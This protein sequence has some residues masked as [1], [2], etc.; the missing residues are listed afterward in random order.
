MIRQKYS[1]SQF[2]IKNTVPAAFVLRA[3]QPFERSLTDA[4]PIDCLSVTP[5]NLCLARIA[6]V[7]WQARA[8]SIQEHAILVANSFLTPLPTE[9][10]LA[11][12]LTI[13]NRPV[14]AAF[15]VAA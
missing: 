10:R 8:F 14:A 13:H 1:N 12:T 15:M 3:V 2:D 9:R 11:S 6:V 4:F 7:A 5:T